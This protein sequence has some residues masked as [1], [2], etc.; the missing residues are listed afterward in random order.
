MV[1]TFDTSDAPHI[2]VVQCNGDLT[3]TGTG[4]KTV[5]AESRRENDL[6][7]E[8]QGESLT[9]TAQR[10]CDLHCPHG[11]SITLK[12]V[13]GDLTAQ[14]LTGPLA[15]EAINGDT[16]LRQVGPTTVRRTGGDLD[17]RGV[18]GEL[19]VESVGGDAQARN[20]SGAVA[21]ESV[22]GDV[23]LREVPG[24]V[25]V[26]R[27]GGDVSL[28][29]PLGSAV[30]RIEAGGDISAKVDISGGARVTIKGGEAHCRLPLQT[31]ERTANRIVGTLGDGSAELT[32]YAGGDATVVE[33][34]E[35]W[36]A[37]AEAEWGAAMESWA[38]Q[39][40][41]Q[42]TDMQRKLEER[43]AGIPYVDHEGIAQRAQEAA[44]RARRQA[45]RAAERAQARA[46]RTRRHAEREAEKSRERAEKAG[47][48]H[49]A[50][51]VNMQWSWSPSQ[52]AKPPV[53]PVSEAER[54]AILKM[55]ADKKI[56]ADD[57]NRLLAALEGEA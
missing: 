11:T 19:R 38:Q 4:E 33:R 45:Q 44:E 28:N 18:Q 43:L 27:A 36:N 9:V 25:T 3:I 23:V 10:D 24:G 40:E 35:T 49:E 6:K 12:Q 16:E 20:V 39:F 37:N 50:R 47:R 42:M 22:G 56:T 31:T 41:A 13:N 14:G 8:R 5:V 51:S 15:V 34:G 32:L 46:E 48:R 17:A 29:T 21:F 54:M 30:F 53:E 55:V 1:L 7:A 26:K 2:T 57:A 52:P